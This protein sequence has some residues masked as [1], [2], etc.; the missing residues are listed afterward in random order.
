MPTYEENKNDDDDYFKVQYD[1]DSSPY[2][3]G[4]KMKTIKEEEEG[5]FSGSDTGYFSNEEEEF[6]NRDDEE[7]YDSDEEY[8]RRKEQLYGGDH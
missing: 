2:H 8:R 7:D 1:R 6:N 5:K 3:A 4:C